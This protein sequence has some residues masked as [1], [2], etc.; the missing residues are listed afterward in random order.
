MDNNLI[1]HIPTNL[2]YYAA[3]CHNQLIYFILYCK[4]EFFIGLPKIICL[5]LFFM[6]LLAVEYMLGTQEKLM[7]NR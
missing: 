6:P 3:F 5:Y 7:R 2:T 1:K 4:R